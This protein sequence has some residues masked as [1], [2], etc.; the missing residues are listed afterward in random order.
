MNSLTIIEPF[1]NSKFDPINCTTETY[2]GIIIRSLLEHVP[3]YA[4]LIKHL[5]S[6]LNENGVLYEASKFGKSEKDP[7]HLSE[8]K[9]LEKILKSYGMKLVYQEGVH[10][11]WKEKS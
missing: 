4:K 3:Y 1:F 9:Q 10:R 7:M 5:I 11:C 6:K 8:K 2:N